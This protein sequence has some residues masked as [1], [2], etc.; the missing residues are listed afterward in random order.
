MVLTTLA[1]GLCLLHRDEH[2]TA[3]DASASFDFCLGLA[4]MSVAVVI[5][6]FVRV[7]P[8]PA[9]APSTLHPVPLHLPDPPPKSGVLY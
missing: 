5:L 7:Y 1:A 3:S 8:L 9:D 4:L 2:G 6:G